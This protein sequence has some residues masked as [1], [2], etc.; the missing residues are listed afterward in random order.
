MLRYLT[1]EQISPVV[2]EQLRKKNPAI[3]IMSLQRWRDG[4]FLNTPD[5]VILREAVREH[6]T[7]VTY[8]QRSRPGILLEWGARDITHEAVLCIDELTTASDGCR[9]LIQS[10]ADFWKE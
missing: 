7:L 10:L 3:P 4:E 1:D 6:L 9:L 5:D 2:A 8:D